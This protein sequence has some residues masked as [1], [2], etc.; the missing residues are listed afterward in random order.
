MKL[1]I[2]L[3]GATG[4]LG[5]NLLPVL[6]KEYEVLS[7]GRNNLTSEFG[8]SAL[9]PCINAETN[10]QCFLSG[11]D[12]V[13]HTAARAHITGTKGII[14]YDE[15]Q[16]VNVEGTRNLAQQAACAG[17]KR[18]IFI[19]SIGVN[20]NTSKNPFKYSDAPDPHDAYS[21]SKH[22]AEVVLQEIERKTGMEYVIIRPPLIYGNKAP[23]NFR[24]LMKLS[25]MNLP[26]PLGA[27]YNK[28]SLVSIDNVVDLIA[29]CINHP[30]A[31]NQLFLVSDDHDVS[32]T[33][34]L[35]EMRVAAGKKPLLLPIRLSILRLVASLFS[36]QSVVD[37]LGSDLQVDIIHTKETLNWKPV[38]SFHDGIRRC[39]N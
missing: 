23:G 12:V 38:V 39:F 19:S 25:N 6:C 27:I 17:I 1:R 11:A 20:G 4:F 10:W 33:E 9:I 34:L 15:Y 37:K 16:E 5:R 14:D 35:Q 26:L 2:V 7:V 13:I 32:T 18:F 3:T 31:K 22:R 21:I 24:S 28:R 29:T 36:K 8:E 30:N